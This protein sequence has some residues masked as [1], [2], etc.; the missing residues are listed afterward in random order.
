MAIRVGLAQINSLLGDFAGNRQK[1]IAQV[2]MAQQKRCDLVVFPEAALFG[3]HPVDLLERPQIVEHQLRELALLHKQI[4]K[5]IGVIIGAIVQNP[6]THGKPY[7]NAAVFLQRGKKS[8]YFPKQLLPTYDVFDEGR[9]IEPGKLRNNLLTFKGQKIL[10]T[11]CE[12]I[13]AWRLQRSPK[14]SHYTK[15]P[16]LEVPARGMDLVIN[17]SASPFTRSKLSN[18]LRVTRK[19]VSRFKCPLVYVNM[20]GA[21][22]ELIFDGGSF[23]LDRKGQLLTQCMRFQ[24]DFN[25]VD[26]KTSSGGHRHWPESEPEV[27]RQAL[28]LGIRD[29]VFKTGFQKVHLGLSGGID[30]AVVACLAVDALGP[31]NVVGVAM[32]GPFSSTLSL[33]LAKKLA[34]NLAIEIHK[35]EIKTLYRQSV[36]QLNKIFGSSKF[37]LMH[38]NLQA[39]LRGVLLMAFANRHN[40]LLLGTSNKSELATGYST[41]YGDMCAAFLPIGDLTKTQVFRLAE[42]Y[43]VES[44]VIPQRIISRPPSAELRAG[45][46]DQDTLPPYKQ[47]DKSVEKMVEQFS[48]V[49]NSL[50]RF[51]LN[52]LMLSEFKRW[53][54]APVLKVTDHAFGRGRRWPVAHKTKIL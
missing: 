45:Q 35:V 2:H 8:K 3:Y 27:L 21:Q 34:N 39:R 20:V 52:K 7:W 1:I 54:A 11:I 44:E 37:S 13:W 50:D 28:V 18:R 40:S 47:L 42:Y 26:L 29:F 46:K 25:L 31:Q 30:S 32:P 48:A 51:V 38:E 22:D 14:Y 49:E 19:T 53:Q 5:N 12:D 23:A 10:V 4:P 24:E 41:L 16:L 33:N 43:N 17:L 9:H 6:D 15:N 36:N